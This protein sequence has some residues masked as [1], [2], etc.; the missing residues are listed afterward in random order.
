[1]GMGVVKD[2]DFERELNNCVPSL[3]KSEN[4]INQETNPTPSET[5][6]TDSVVEGEVVGMNSPG[7]KAGDNNVPSSLR[8]IIAD[9]SLENGRASALE[10]AR[11]FDVSSSSVSAYSNGATSTKS[12]DTPNSNINGF[13]EGRKS[14][15]A[16]RA[17][18][19]LN[20]ALSN[21]TP[22]K[23]QITKAK[24]L[25][26]IAKDMSAIVRNMEPENKNPLGGNNGVQ[27]ILYAPP[28]KNESSYDVIHVNE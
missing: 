6:S 27:F 9:E 1:M 8:N 26:S 20:S 22:D 21:I 25:A 4:K 3:K 19:K 11:M 14:K 23:L 5:P 24:D 10:L 13:L 16:S 15:I 18:S 17:I 2:E 12:Y 7:R 28:I